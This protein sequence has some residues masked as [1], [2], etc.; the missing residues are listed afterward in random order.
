M[1]SLG[2]DPQEAIDLAEE[3]Y[4]GYVDMNGNSENPMDKMLTFEDFLRI[5]KNL[6]N[7]LGLANQNQDGS[8]IGVG[9]E[10][11]NNEQNFIS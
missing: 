3:H 10:G 6:E 9:S 4:Y 5:M 1:Q 11:L 2:R 7:R 8:Q